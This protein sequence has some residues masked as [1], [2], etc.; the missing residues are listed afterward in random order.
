MLTALTL[1][2]FLGLIPAA[3]AKSKGRSFIMWWAYGFLLL[4][5]ALP[6]SIVLKA[7]QEA[8]DKASRES[9]M[10]KCPNCAE[11]VQKEAKLCRY[12]NTA[13]TECDN[14]ID[15][16][17]EIQP[18]KV[19][20]PRAILVTVAILLIGICVLS[21]TFWVNNS[22]S[23]DNSNTISQA[24]A[25]ASSN[26][27]TAPTATHAAVTTPM[28]LLRLSGYGTKSTQF[29]T[30]PTEWKLV[31]QYDCS[32]FGDGR[33]NFIVSVFDS[34]GSPAPEAGVNQLGASGSDTEYYHQGGTIYL[35]INSECRWSVNVVG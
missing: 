16:L 24:S 12:C 11:W 21:L 30:V 3:I 9:G 29:V 8:V 33:G 34:N 23:N 17:S 15:T 18:H 5:V 7:T 19:D 1:A 4:I 35:E 10:K 26:A 31:W 2:V 25:E 14:Q 20:G 32:S 28:S 27:T 22:S 13:F 6:H